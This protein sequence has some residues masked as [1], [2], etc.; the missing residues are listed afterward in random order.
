M[1]VDHYTS[2][3]G[4]PT[5]YADTDAETAARELH[6]ARAAFKSAIASLLKLETA[7]YKLEPPSRLIDKLRDIDTW[8]NLQER[9]FAENTK[10][11]E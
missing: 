5:G 9:V 10:G 8:V 6:E 11:M 4:G 1:K 2:R 3:D 7:L